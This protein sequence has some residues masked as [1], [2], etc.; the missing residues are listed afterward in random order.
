MN[1]SVIHDSPSLFIF[2]FLFHSLGLDSHSWQA[3]FIHQLPSMTNPCD[4]SLISLPFEAFT[5]SPNVTQLPPPPCTRHPWRWREGGG[6]PPTS[7]NSSSLLVIQ[8]VLSLF[9]WTFSFFA[10][11]YAFLTGLCGGGGV[12]HGVAVRNPIN[13]EFELKI[14][15]IYIKR[16]II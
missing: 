10:N 4:V 1:G 5:K 12:T 3:W 13:R 6:P 7:S 16:Q 8:S 9:G 14:V 15:C 2:Y 11:A